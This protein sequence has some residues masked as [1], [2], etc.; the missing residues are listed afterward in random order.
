[1]RRTS[2]HMQ[3]FLVAALGLTVAS[4]SAVCA[5]E[6]TTLKFG[7]I[8]AE[9]HPSNLWAKKFAEVAA[10]KSGGRLRVQVFPANQL[11]KD[12]ELMEGIRVGNVD[13][14]LNGVWIYTL[15][16]EVQVLDYPFLY[17]DR[18]HY[19]KTV[20][21]PLFKELQAK[22]EAK[23]FKL[24][25]VSE[26]GVRMMTN[27]KR[28]IKTP[29]DL[30]GL[31]MRV[32]EG[33]VYI[34]MME[35]LGATVVPINFAEVYLALRQGVVDGQENPLPTIRAQKYY[36]VQKHVSLTR[37]MYS[38]N[39]A[40]FNLKKFNG[41]APDLQ[42]AITD[43]VSEATR[44]G[45]DLI[46]QDERDSLEFIKSRGMIVT[47]PDRDLFRK[48][49]DAVADKLKDQVPLEWVRRVRDTQ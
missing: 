25:G 49:T 15:V 38:S 7:H 23:G 43:A 31:K 47:E 37:H 21:G 11:G 30:V 16:P 36:E 35:S 33:K 5:G 9:T 22:A 1:M 39:Y 44:Y 10:A 3:V 45:R 4:A 41:L 18:S 42:R 17:R 32:P 8:A 13:M 40:T 20:D 29:Q 24:L 14:A 34:T 6:P 48:A 19:Y 26:F 27:N 12:N 28:P 46:E 2:L